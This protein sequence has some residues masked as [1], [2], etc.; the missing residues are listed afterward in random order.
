[1]R[2][3]DA[4]RVA[5]E[6][7]WPVLT[8]A[9]LLHDLF[10]SRALLKLAAAKWLTE[11]EYLSLLRP[12]SADLIDVLWTEGDIALLD[13]ARYDL[14]PRPG[15]NGKLLEDEEIRT[16][17]HIVIDEVQD[18]SPMQLRMMSRRSLN[19]SMTVVGDIAQATGQHAP[20]DWSDILVHL[21]DKRPARVTEL[22]VGYRI[23][24]PTMELAAKV[25]R[26]AAPRVTPPTSVRGG[27]GRPEIV[28]SDGATFG[29]TVGDAVNRL[30]ARVGDGNVAVVVPG[31]LHE[32][33]VDALVVAGIHF[34]RAAT[35][36]LDE[37]VTVVPV[38]MVKGLEL[39]AVVVV[40]PA[41]IVAE[42]P[43]G[44]RSLYVA[45]T[46]ATKYLTIV[47]AEALPPAL[48]D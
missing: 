29:A 10:G 18:L 1:V 32:A 47:H 37:E 25:L 20:H 21:P 5:L 17:G 22:T 24:S 19:G 42:E 48:A 28:A 15:K 36:G 6:R 35:Q 16:Y 9:Q 34:G 46:R 14:G 8:P 27:D 44:L 3:T 11:D 33:I 2:H 39:D 43:Q 38:G 31:S 4:I 30:R 41:R 26:V 23:P 40:E 7:M 45:L 13:E 12:R